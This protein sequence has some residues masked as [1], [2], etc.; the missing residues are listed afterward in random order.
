MDRRDQRRVIRIRHRSWEFTHSSKTRDEDYAIFSQSR[1]RFGVAILRDSHRTIAETSNDTGISRSF[2]HFFYFSSDFLRLD[3]FEPRAFFTVFLRDRSVEYA[4]EEE[5]TRNEIKETLNVH[6][7]NEFVAQNQGTKDD[8]DERISMFVDERHCAFL[9]SSVFPSTIR[10]YVPVFFIARR[11][12][13]GIATRAT[14]F[15][16]TSKNSYALQLQRQKNSERPMFFQRPSN[17]IFEFR[18][19]NKYNVA[20]PLLFR[21]VAR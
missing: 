17:R 1:G 14:F 10:G 3:L 13:I 6:R 9:A 15:S 5:R 19:S 4:R 11:C 20:S 2:Y 7:G 8:I 21:R 18:R 12:D 16:K